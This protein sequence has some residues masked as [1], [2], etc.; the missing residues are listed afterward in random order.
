VRA[1]GFGQA[2]WHLEEALDEVDDRVAAVIQNGKAPFWQNVREAVEA[3]KK[4][5][6]AEGLTKRLAKRRLRLS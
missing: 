5:P 6:L 1:G 3:K 4:Q 2:K